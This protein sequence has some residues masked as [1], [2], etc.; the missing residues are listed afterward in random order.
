MMSKLMIFV[1]HR[2][3][4]QQAYMR[5]C[6]IFSDGKPS[7][8]DADNCRVDHVRNQFSN[9]SDNSCARLQDCESVGLVACH[10]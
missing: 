10:F 5:Y 6:Q 3:R 2:S 9:T 4:Q 7:G 1:L 8:N